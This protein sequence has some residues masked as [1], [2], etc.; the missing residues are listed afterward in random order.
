MQDVQQSTHEEADKPALSPRKA[1]LL[2]T[3]AA[4]GSGLIASLTS[5]AIMFVLRVVGG[6]PSP[7]ELFGDHLL[8]LLPAARFVDMLIMFSPH[9]KTTPLGLAL[10]GM[11]GLGTFL[12]LLYAFF[13]QVKLPATGYRPALREWLTALFLTIAMTSAA[14]ILFW[15]EIG[16]NFLGLPLGRAM[17]VTSLALLADFSFYG[18]VLCVAYRI[19]LPKQQ[20][21]GIAMRTSERRQLLARVGVVALGAG[22]AIGTVGLIKGLL[23]NYTTYDGSETFTHNGFTAPITPTS[24]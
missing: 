2:T 8:K 1:F 12:G 13:V 15:V 4:L 22:S 6:I 24:E 10:L 21:S 9:S 16:Q 5:V 3:I 18:L 19:L 14:I 7:M 11:I 17:L 23:S 20:V